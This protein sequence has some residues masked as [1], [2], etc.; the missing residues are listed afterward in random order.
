MALLSWSG[1]NCWPGCEASWCS[2][3]NFAGLEWGCS[4]GT[5]AETKRAQAK[6]QP[7]LTSA[8]QSTV[9]MLA[10]QS[11]GKRQ[12]CWESMEGCKTKRRVEDEP[13]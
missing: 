1:W 2:G 5:A 10:W 11:K 12:E 4:S 7:P 13:A 8:S 9:A 3:E 6:P